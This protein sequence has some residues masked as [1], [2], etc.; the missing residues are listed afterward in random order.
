[1]WSDCCAIDLW[2]IE[3]SNLLNYV[4]TLIESLTDP[5]GEKYESCSMDQYDSGHYTTKKEYYS[6]I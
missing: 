6:N 3:K 4:L 5:R 1:M 2:E